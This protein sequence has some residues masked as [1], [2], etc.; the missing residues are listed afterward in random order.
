MAETCINCGSE[1]FYGQKF[2]RSC[3]NS[4]DSSSTAEAPTQRMPPQP[5]VWGARGAANTAPTPKPGTNPVYAPPNYYQP[6]VPPVP[7]QPIQPMP[8]YQPPRSRSWVPILVLIIL[9]LFGGGFLAV[10]SIVRNI[11]GQIAN[12]VEVRGGAPSSSVTEKQTYAL[13]KGAA[14]SIATLNGEI[15]VEAWDQQ[16]AEV[17][18]I[19]RSKNG[20]DIQSLPITVKSDKDN[21]L[22]DATQVRGDIQ[23]SFEVKLPRNLGAVKFT[24]TN[25]SINLSDI[26]GNIIVEATNGEIQLDNVSGVER[27]TTVNGGIE[28]ELKSM[29]TD[30]PMK[31]ETTNGEI[32]LSFNPDFNANLDASTVH[33]SIDIDDEIGINVQKSRPFGQKANGA[34]GKGGPPLTVTTVNGGINISR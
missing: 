7:M 20:V 19:K 16:Q 3:G 14:F 31:F 5:D 1:L 8:P 25:G 2:C 6:T 28:A 32:N 12:H 15:K 17:K 26:S 27:V 34:I 18:I 23:I 22:F 33:G 4:T 30:R 11:R 21:L 24:S 29:P 9:L 10:R 13:N